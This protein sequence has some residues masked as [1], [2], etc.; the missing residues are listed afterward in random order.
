MS[1]LAIWCYVALI[2]AVFGFTW[3][4]VESMCD[5]TSKK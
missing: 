5:K 1:L 4:A 3:M 2:I